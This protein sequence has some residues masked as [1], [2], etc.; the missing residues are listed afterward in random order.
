MSNDIRNMQ[1]AE[2]LLKCAKVPITQRTADQISEFYVRLNDL[3]NALRILDECL[4]AGVAP[5]ISSF[6]H[7]IRLACRQGDTYAV[8][9]TFTKLKNICKSVSTE[10]E[11]PQ[12]IVLPVWRTALCANMPN[13][14]TECW[15][16]VYTKRWTV[17]PLIVNSGLLNATLL[18]CGGIGDYKTV[19]Q[20]VKAFAGRGE[21]ITEEHYAAVFEALARSENQEALEKMMQYMQRDEARFKRIV[22]MATDRLNSN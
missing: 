1:N 17:N 3:K 22:R 5:S 10:T 19:L 2:S 14:I 6:G 13:L 20:I 4:S 11:L 18:A 8:L 12:W 7:A 9:Q 16:V 21:K 15:H